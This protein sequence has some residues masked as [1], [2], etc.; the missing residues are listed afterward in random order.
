MGELQFTVLDDS[1]STTIEVVDVVAGDGGQEE[2]M[3]GGEDLVI[4]FGTTPAP[5]PDPNPNPDPEPNPDPNQPDPY[6]NPNPDPQPNPDPNQP[7]P[8]NPIPGDATAPTAPGGLAGT[9]S[10]TAVTIA[11]NGS[12]DTGGIDEYRIERARD[13]GQFRQIAVV[14]GTTTQYVD[15]STLSDSDY[16]YRVRAVDTS[17]NVSGYSNVLSIETEATEGI[18]Q[19]VAPGLVVII[20]PDESFTPPP[21]PVVQ[22]TPIPTPVPTPVTVNPAP[23]PADRV[24]PLPEPTP[25]TTPTPT[26]EPT[27]VPEPATDLV[28]DVIAGDVTFRNAQITVANEDTSR[29]FINY[30]TSA[31][32]LDLRSREVIVDEDE[33]SIT[34]E[35]GGL[36]PGETYFYQVVGL[37]SD[38]DE[39]LGEVLSFTTSGY[40]VNVRLMDVNEN[41]I[42]GQDVTLF[43]DPVDGVTNDAGEVSFS[44]ISPGEHE[45][46]FVREDVE[47][48]LP[49]TVVDTAGELDNS[50]P[51]QSFELVADGVDLSG[52]GSGILGWIVLGLLLIGLL[53]VGAWILFRFMRGGGSGGGGDGYQNDAHVITPGPLDAVRHDQHFSTPSSTPLGAPPVPHA[54][55]QV[56]DSFVPNDQYQD[57]P[58]FSGPLDQHPPHNNG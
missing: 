7:A 29:F 9:S 35:L 48:S 51:A 50:A 53:A 39:I 32:N 17:G 18:V 26:P 15:S 24:E 25:A 5:D 31:D 34:T 21:A 54:P 52:G 42:V 37:N 56:G 4:S 11:W 47:F 45:L 40:D 49:L 8:V 6:P 41:P 23:D 13:G 43:S 33:D 58:L 16:R 12:T 27:E 1:S 20:T 22:A 36:E 14:N 30:G 57:V 19:Q 38:G 10:A 2:I 44:N 46:T 28:G 3:L 55:A